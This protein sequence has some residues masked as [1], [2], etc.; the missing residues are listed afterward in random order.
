MASIIKG[1]IQFSRNHLAAAGDK[2]SRSQTQT[3]SVRRCSL[4]LVKF[5]IWQLYLSSDEQIDG[6]AL[7]LSESDL[8]GL[9]PNTGP[10]SKFRMLLSQL[11]TDHTATSTTRVVH[12][13]PDARIKGTEVGPW[14]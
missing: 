8:C 12:P 4:A 3:F 10:R 6:Q 13:N 1:Y 9:V 7:L 2:R 11:K 5:V 14:K